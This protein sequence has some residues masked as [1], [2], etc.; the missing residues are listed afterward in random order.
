MTEALTHGAGQDLL[1]AWKRAWEARD[2]DALVA[3]FAEEGDMRLDP[4]EEA[5]VGELA[6]RAHW[7]TFAERHIHTELDAERIWVKDRTVL[8]SWHGAI[9]DRHTAQRSRLRGFF[10]FDLDQ[11]GCIIRL[12]GWPVEQVVGIDSTFKPEPPGPGA[13]QEGA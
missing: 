3:L 5:L 2:V 9:T 4:F 12:R 6:L 13:A 1:A 7:T 10:A 11:A 8:A